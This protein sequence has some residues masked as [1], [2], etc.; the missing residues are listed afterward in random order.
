MFLD[1]GAG[2]PRSLL[3]LAGRGAAGAAGSLVGVGVAVGGAVRV[4]V[5]DVFAWSRDVL[6]AL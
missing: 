1:V 4:R 3:V 5:F 6:P 2:D